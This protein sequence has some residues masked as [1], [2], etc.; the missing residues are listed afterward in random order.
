MAFSIEQITC[1]PFSGRYTVGGQANRPSIN[2]PGTV[3]KAQQEL[4]FTAALYLQQSMKFIGFLI[5][6]A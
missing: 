6:G 4:D 3:D 2:A 1:L 5:I